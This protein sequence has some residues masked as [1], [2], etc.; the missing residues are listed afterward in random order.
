[1]K[2]KD[3]PYERVDLEALGKELD[4]LTAKVQ[5]A[6]DADTVIEA[7]REQEKLSVH[8]QTMISLV[9]VRNSIDT[10]DEYYSAEKEF[11]D[12]NLPAFQA[13][14]QNF[15]LA[16]Y[17]SPFRAEV[18]KVVG[19]LMFI[20]LEMSLKT[21]SP[22]VIEELGMENK[23]VSEYQKLIASAKIEFDGKTLNISQLG[24]Y[25]ENPD[26]EVRHAAYKAESGFYMSHAEE[27]D[28]IFDE[29][30]KV[31]TAIAKK[32]GFKNFTELAYLR[33]TRNC[34]NPEMV[35]N[36]RRQVV[37]D[38][39][40]IVKELKRRQAER[41]GLTPE[42]MCIYDD[43]FSFKEG[44]PKPMGTPDD[45]MAAGKQMYEEM[46]P[47]TAEFINFMY[48]NELLDLVAKEGKAVGGYCTEF[49]EYKAPFIFSN[50]NG[51]SGDVDVLTH[52]AGHA[53]AAYTTRDFE[54][55]DTAQPTMESCECHSMSMEFFAW[56]WL[57]LFYGDDTD[58]AKYM[59]LESA[60]IFIPYGCMVDHFQ[61]IVYDNPELTPAQRHEEWL[62]LEAMYR[63]YMQ[64]GDVE[65]YGSGRGWQRQLH[66]YHYP[67][68]YID[69]CLAQTVSL[70]FW[71]M[72]QKDYADA[73]ERY[74]KF[75]C[76][77]G[78]K[79]FV[80]L[81]EVADIGVPFEDGAL[82]SIAETAVDYLK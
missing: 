2:F 68:Y 54:F 27:L 70:E 13:H 19:E 69:Y 67:F 55:M 66:I 39:V 3:M 16:I 12:T 5:N 42:T 31:R 62:K 24:A 18:A 63:P 22:E 60:L 49:P 7:V 47:Q 52:E 4:A 17:N 48:D 29:L 50:F 80:G 26:R 8:A 1:M 75:V 34:Y 74:Y 14:S 51:T 78:K 64:F 32:L 81:C 6:K 37:S 59:H 33:R 57:N 45:I 15:A 72:S 65:F 41:I 71:S 35:A 20:N 56:K 21:F 30:V 77:G 79:T 10:R 58:R 38:L 43:P 82:K 61:H 28:R 11:Y 9:H 40:P 76:E 53:F 36:F 23:L 73:W 25:K 44:N 46:S